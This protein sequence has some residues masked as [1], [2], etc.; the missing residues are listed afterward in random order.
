MNIQNKQARDDYSRVKAGVDGMLE[1]A[2]APSG[3]ASSDAMGEGALPAADYGGAEGSGGMQEL[4]QEGVQGF[5]QGAIPQVAD[6][7]LDK[8]HEVAEAIVNERFD[9]LMSSVGNIPMWKEKV[10]T[11]IISIKQEM[12]RINNR[13]ENIQN[14]VLGKVKDYDQSMKDVYTEMKALERVFEK[15]LEP[16]VSNIKELDRITRELKMRR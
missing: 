13:V 12:L 2:P 4:G 1:D 3:P 10:E 6:V 8:L 16:M 9:E 5:G 14:A 15:V 11:N 7:N